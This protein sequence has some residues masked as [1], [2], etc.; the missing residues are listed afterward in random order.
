MTGE[1][2]EIKRIHVIGCGVSRDSLPESARIAISDAEIVAGA[3]RLLEVFAEEKHERV[4]IGAN[5]TETIK[6][7]IKASETRNVAIL[8]SGDALF[9]ES[10]PHSLDSRIPNTLQSTRTSPLFRHSAR[11]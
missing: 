6:H 9:T 3:Q 1:Q 4:V 2:I 8:A 10:A 7:L 11:N 5:L